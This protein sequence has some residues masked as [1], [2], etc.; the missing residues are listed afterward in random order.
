MGV[1]LFLRA[2]GTDPLRL[3]YGNETVTS[4]LARLAQ[5]PLR[6]DA[7]E[8]DHALHLLAERAGAPPPAAARR[9]DHIER[10]HVDPRTCDVAATPPRFRPCITDIL[11]Q[12]TE[13]FCTL[14]SGEWAP[15]D[16]FPVSTAQD[17]DV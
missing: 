15:I 14:S 6:L 12:Y 3:R 13:G 8:R 17:A 2:N 10:L 16:E 9:V 7:D 5:T 11:K 4:F 1:L